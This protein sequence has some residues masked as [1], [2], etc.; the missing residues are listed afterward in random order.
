[1][2]DINKIAGMCIR[3]KKLLVVRDRGETMFFALGGKMEQAETELE[4]LQREIME[5]IGCEPINPKHM[6]TFEGRNHD[7]TKSIKMICYTCEL[8]G[9]I[10]P[11]SE[12]EEIAWIDK[13]YKNKGIKI[14]SILEIYVIPYLIKKGLL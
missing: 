11:C 3:D 7:N 8:K 4:C 12:I 13:E 2:A 14:A 10:Q 1:M 9:T 5:E 6:E